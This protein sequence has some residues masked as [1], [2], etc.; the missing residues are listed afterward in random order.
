M[1]PIK[2]ISDSTCDLSKELLQK[3]DIDTIPLYVNFGDE[4]YF[5]GVNLS[6][7][8]MYDL[9]KVRGVLPKTAAVAPGTFTELF[10][11][12]LDLGYQILFMGIG[13]N[14]SATFQSANVAKQLVDSPDIHLIDSANLSSGTGLLLLKAAKFRDQGDDIPAIEKK[15]KELIPKVRT[16]FVIDT[17]EYLYKGGRCNSLVAFVGTVLKIKPIIKVREGVMAVGKKGRGKI[18]SGIDLMIDELRSV[19]HQLDED[20]LMV[21]DSMASEAVAYT[22]EKIADIPVKNKYH[23]E[24]GCVISSHC[25]AGC[26]GIL[27]IL[28]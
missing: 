11:K 23:T 14:F 1:K 18:T 20:F 19:S 24:A 16:Q 22:L 8:E 12:Y 28:K 26:I 27:Y 9:I 21:T 5:D 15:I 6:V 4:S 7:Q 13:A 2:L 25:G 10:K 17:M 3:H